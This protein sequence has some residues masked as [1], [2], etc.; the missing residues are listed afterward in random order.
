[1]CIKIRSKISFPNYEALKSDSCA[2]PVFVRE[3]VCV[4]E[5]IP[6]TLIKST[7]GWRWVPG[8]CLC[9]IE[10]WCASL[11]RDFQ[12]SNRR[13]R[14]VTSQVVNALHL[15]VMWVYGVRQA[16]VRSVGGEIMF[17]SLTNRWGTNEQLEC[18][19]VLCCEAYLKLKG[20]LL[21][22]FLQDVIYS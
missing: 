12:E 16:E 11:R 2:P 20:E 14:G 15:T 13:P 8:W 19:Q 17:E 7:R 9:V 21:C 4:R 6:L 10:F 5:A 3:S 18:K 1:M 22:H